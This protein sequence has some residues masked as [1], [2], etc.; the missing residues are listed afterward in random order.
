MEGKATMTRHRVLYH[1][2]W[3]GLVLALASPASAAAPVKWDQENEL[4]IGDE[5]ATRM[6]LRPMRSPWHL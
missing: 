1:A 6:V 5:Q 2:I 4:F 3:I